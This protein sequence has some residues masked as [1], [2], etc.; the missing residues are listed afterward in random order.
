MSALLELASPWAYLVVG[1]LAAAEASAFVGLF[2]PGEAVMLLGG[3]LASQGRVDLRSMLVAACIGAVVGDSIGFEIGRRF[4][5]RMEGSRLGRRVGRHR[6][7]RARAYVRRR[8]GRAVFFGRFVGVFR[9][10]VPAVAGTAGIPYRTFLIFNIA[11]GVIWAGAFVLLGAT[12]GSSYRIVEA[13]AGR[14]SL[15]LGT[16]IAIAVVIGLIARWIG[17]H[18]FEL[19]RKRDVFLAL[20]RVVRLRVRF[21]SQIDFAKDRLDPNQRLGLYVTLGLALVIAGTWIFG[22]ILQD[23]VAN[24]EIALLDRPVLRFFVTH[25]SPV[26]NDVIRT[27]TVLGS[28]MVVTVTIALAAI[29]SFLMTR[30]VRWPVFLLLT[31]GGA[32]GLDDIVEA[33]VDRPGPS[34]NPLL[35]VTGSSFP[36]GHATAAAALF[37]SL[38]FVMTRERGWRANVWIWAAAAFGSFLVALSRVYLGVA[39]PTDV[40]GGLV[41]G[42]SW[43]A[44]SATALALK[45]APDGHRGP[46]Y[47]HRARDS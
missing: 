44:V 39:W 8:G 1:A 38:A 21:R 10:L 42:G 47:A 31:L 3:V 18:Q 36:S 14:A 28:T 15:V 45:R 2:I 33:L 20:P 9:A 41:L 43:T 27:I 40:L 23:V 17:A 37:G 24:E 6:W 26:F 30:S 5:P 12:A 32:I 11:G 29:I 34:F 13:W 25:R 7:E 22:A 35:P 46:L 16:I 4:G 19:A